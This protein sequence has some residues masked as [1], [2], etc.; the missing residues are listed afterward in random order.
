MT[1][2]IFPWSPVCLQSIPKEVYYVK[3]TSLRL[4][5]VHWVAKHPILYLEEKP[6]G[7]RERERSFWLGGED[8][9]TWPARSEENQEVFAAQR[10]DR[11]A[12]GT[13]HLLQGCWR[14]YLLCWTG[15]RGSVACKQ[16]QL[17]SIA[18]QP[19]HTLMI[20][21]PLHSLH[22]CHSSRQTVLHNWFIGLIMVRP[23]NMTET[24][25]CLFCIGVRE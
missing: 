8:W 3:V 25:W 23:S 4:Q 16:L 13:T 18:N 10:S 20:T 7:E 1:L 9:G 14:C 12:S 11:K 2:C 17:K 22:V 6:R 21:L 15:N 5:R 19:P 24:Y